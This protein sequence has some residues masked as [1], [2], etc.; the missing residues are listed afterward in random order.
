M[1]AC[2]RSA[3]E[4]LTGNPYTWE[5]LENLTGYEPKRAAWTVK[6]W[7]ELSQDGFDI[8]MIEGFDYKK[9]HEQGEAYLHIFLKPEEVEWQLRES[10]L[11]QI[12]PLIPTFLK[13]VQYEQR[14][15][16]LDDIDTMLHD[17]FL[18]FVQLNSKILNN[19]DGYTAHMIL[20]HG[21]EGDEYIAH[22][23][24]L[25]PHPNRHIPKTLLLKAMGGINNTVEVTGIKLKNVEPL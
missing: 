12:R 3:F 8:R 6:I 23:P 5:Q 17:G 18:V 11:A 16:Q 7:T 1:L 2:F 24:G 9:Y 21:K 25:P 20:L 22:D 15:P 10:N 4:Y 13:N 14:S 19:K